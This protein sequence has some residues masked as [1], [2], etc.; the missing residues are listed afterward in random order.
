MK[1][2]KKETVILKDVYPDLEFDKYLQEH[3]R[4][5]LRIMYQL[6]IDTLKE[7]D[8]L[9]IDSE[10]SSQDIAKERRAIGQQITNLF[11]R[12]KKTK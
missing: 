8:D 10:L 1:N 12:I 4:E 5:T 7:I 11:D 9:L 3:D 6:D 2:D